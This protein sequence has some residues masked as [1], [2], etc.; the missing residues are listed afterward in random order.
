M[1]L[2]EWLKWIKT[3]H[4]KCWKGCGK[5]ELDSHNASGN[6]NWYNHSGKVW[7]FCKEI[8]IQI[9][10]NSAIPLPGFYLKVKNACVHTKICTQMFTAAISYN[11][12]N[13][14][15][16]YASTSKCIK[17]CSIFIKQ[18]LRNKKGVNC[19]YL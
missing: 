2:L 3:D 9:P 4:T 6:A 1:H 16:K 15:P 14:K 8:N 10:Y 19:W 18:I 12:K 11:T 13:G 7:Q 5:T 17:N